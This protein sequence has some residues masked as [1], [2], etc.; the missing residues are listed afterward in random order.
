MLIFIFLFWFLGFE[1]LLKV[2]CP[3]PKIVILYLVLLGETLQRSD[4][5]FKIGVYCKY[6]ENGKN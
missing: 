3:W 2:L 5:L 1:I 4:F 6:L